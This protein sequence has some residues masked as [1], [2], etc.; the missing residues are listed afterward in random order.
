[1]KLD[2]AEVALLRRMFAAFRQDCLD[3]AA[4][5]WERKVSLTEK[6]ERGRALLEDIKAA[7]MVIEKL[8]GDGTV[9]P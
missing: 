8:T 7:R 3:E 1:M 6:A 5:P 2:D 9:A 4:A